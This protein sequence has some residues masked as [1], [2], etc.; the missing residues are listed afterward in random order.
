MSSDPWRK[1]I[2]KA[3]RKTGNQTA[4]EGKLGYQ[5]APEGKLGYQTAPETNW[6]IKYRQ[7]GTG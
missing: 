7:R 3:R 1:S 2:K 4:P 6:D 5:T